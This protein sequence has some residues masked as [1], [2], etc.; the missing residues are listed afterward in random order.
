VTH[1]KILVVGADSYIGRRVMT[2]LAGCDWATPVAQNGLVGR[3]LIGYDAIVN[4][5]VGKPRHIL[6]AAH[7]LFGAATATSQPP[8]I[9]H[10]SSMTVYGSATGE[11]DE[12]AALLADLSDYAAAQ[13][14]AER[15]AA[16]YPRVIIL[17]PGCEYGPGCPQ[18]T[19]RVARWL[20]AHRLGDLGAAGDG[21][22]NLL[23][24]DD[25]VVAIVAALQKNAIEGRT[26]NLAMSNPPTWNEYLG[27]F[28]RAL[29]AVPVRRISRRYLALEA[30]IFSAPLKLAE[31]AAAAMKISMLRPPPAIPPSFLRLCGQELVLDVRRAETDLGIGWT[32]L[33]EGLAAAAAALN[34]GAGTTSA[35]Q[36][37]A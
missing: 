1:K 17:R 35:G 19:E 16:L 7:A 33:D 26:Y 27:R 25:L 10:L 8:R 3:S 5:T 36:F 28:A 20:I 13:L 37:R 31:L 9:V 4:C 18:W 34:R 32:L 22:C 6:A 23:Y 30:H 15:R 24:I 2:A 21:Y 14:I 12:D 29:G 11:V